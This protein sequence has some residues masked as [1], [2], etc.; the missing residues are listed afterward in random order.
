VAR[1][2]IAIG[3]DA[4][5]VL[6]ALG[7]RVAV[8]LIAFGGR[9]LGLLAVGG[10]AL[11]VFAFGGLAAGAIVVGGLGL[12]WQAC[13]G[14]AVAWDTAY[15]GS[16]VAWHTAVGGLA[17]AHD[18]ASGGAAWAQQVDPLV[19]DPKDMTALPAGFRWVIAHPVWYCLDI[20]LAVLLLCSLRLLLMYQRRPPDPDSQ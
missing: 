8:G 9:A 1:G 16:A 6:F 14:G 20:I 15:G 18:Q 2:W 4:Y 12:G 10:A 7:G 13:G 17:I 5:G 3:D 11:G 19:A